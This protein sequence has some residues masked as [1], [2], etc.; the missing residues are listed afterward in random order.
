[1]R[2]PLRVYTFDVPTKSLTFRE[3]LAAGLNRASKLQIDV[4]CQSMNFQLTN[5]FVL[6]SA[7]L[8]RRRLGVGRQMGRHCLFRKK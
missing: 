3:D 5:C 7:I 4:S 8:A 1:M 6:L 2:F